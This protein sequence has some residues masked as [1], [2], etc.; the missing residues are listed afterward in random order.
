MKMVVGVGGQHF[1]AHF[2]FVFR[3]ACS[4]MPLFG[5]KRHSGDRKRKTSSGVTEGSRSGVTEGNSNAT[6]V[7][8]PVLAPPNPV[9]NNVRPHP[10]SMIPSRRELLFHCQLAHGS[11][12]Q[13]IKDFSNV[14]ELYH[15]IASAFSLHKDD[16]SVLS[17]SL[18]LECPGLHV[19]ESVWFVFLGNYNGLVYHI[20]HKFLACK[21]ILRKAST[22]GLP[23]SIQF[24][25]YV[26]HTSPCPYHSLAQHLL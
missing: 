26:L 6:V 3:V 16:V 1:N 23:P 12:T 11:A 21:G 4:I 2:N 20:N 7:T 22:K 13:Q 8:A 10:Q 19:M 18:H 24:V 15:K 5:Q 9:E 14:K 17:I 25:P